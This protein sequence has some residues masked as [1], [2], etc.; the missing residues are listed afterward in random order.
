M[1]G[2]FD[3]YARYYDL[4]YRDKDY[5]AEAAYVA[6]HLTGGPRVLELGCGTGAH[7]EQLARLGF[8]VHG[9]DL[10]ETMLERARARRAGLPPEIAARMSF[11]HGDIRS[12]RTGEIYDAAISLFH[13]TSYQAANA[14]LSAAFRTAAAHLTPGGRYL[15]DYWYGPAELAQCPEPRTRL[16]ED[17]HIQV[18]RVARPDLR[19]NEN[20]VDVNYEVQIRVKKTG[21]YQE[22]RETHRMRYLFEPE[23]ALLASLGDWTELHTRAWMKASPPGLEDWSAF[24]WVSRR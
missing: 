20:V 6:S 24:S 7:A 8:S 17:E 21:V 16:L 23:L 11:G 10:S 14:D 15:F 5:T 19:V 9:V 3:A 1:S 12:V 13:V 18:K 4:L 22:V 2:V